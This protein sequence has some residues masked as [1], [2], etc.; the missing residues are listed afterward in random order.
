MADIITV[1]VNGEPRELRVPPEMPL[2]W[3]LREEL[4]L[5]GTKLS[6]GIGLCG[7]CTVHVSG[8]AVRSCVTPIGEVS[9]PVTTIEGLSSPGGLH[10]VQKAWIENAV[11]QCGFC[12]SG[13]IMAAAALVDETPGA[14]HAEL[15][16]QMTNICRCSTFSRVRLAMLTA[17]GH[18]VKSHD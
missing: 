8:K 16:Q 14:Q 9:G 4:G 10:P 15:L 13:F 12:Q 18:G 7:A 5:T 6:C 3:A 11:A 1:I 17:A 2:V